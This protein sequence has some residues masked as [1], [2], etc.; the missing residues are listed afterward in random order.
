MVALA[1]GGVKVKVLVGV[2]VRVKVLV[3]LVGV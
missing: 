1:G 3:A 2:L